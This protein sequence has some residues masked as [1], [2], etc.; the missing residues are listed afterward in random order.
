MPPRIVEIV[1]EKDSLIWFS[2]HENKYRIS[3]YEKGKEGTREIKISRQSAKAIY[4]FFR[5]VLDKLK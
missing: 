1:G 2:L 4:I 3:I 5:N